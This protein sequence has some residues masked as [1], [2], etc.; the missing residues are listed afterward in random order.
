MY[1]LF[2]VLFKHSL[3]LKS[4][5]LVGTISCCYSISDKSQQFWKRTP[6][7]KQITVYPQRWCKCSHPHNSSKHHLIVIARVVGI[8]LFFVIICFVSFLHVAWYSL[9]LSTVCSFPWYRVVEGS[10]VY[11]FS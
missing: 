6:F 7:L 11:I 3:L 5:L 1:Y 8:T 10:D 4:P 9:P 2:F